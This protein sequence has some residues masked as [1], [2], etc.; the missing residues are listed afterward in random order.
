LQKHTSPKKASSGKRKRK[1]AL[2]K[3]KKSHLYKAREEHRNKIRHCAS[4]KPTLHT[5]K[6]LKFYEILAFAKKEMLKKANSLKKQR[7][8][9]K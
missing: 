5:L 4:G 9:L 3:N 1:P 6:S 7:F 2:E 8:F